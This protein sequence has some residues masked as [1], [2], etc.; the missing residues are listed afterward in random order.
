MEHWSM[1]N[2]PVSSTFALNP[3]ARIRVSNVSA[4]PSDPR[5]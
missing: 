4:S 2:A 3:R 5:T 1:Q